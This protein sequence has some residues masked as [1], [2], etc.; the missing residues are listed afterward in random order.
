M[1]QVEEVKR[2]V[3]IVDIVGEKVALK[4]AGRN[5]KGL[6]PFHGERTPSFM[7][8]EELQIYKCFGCGKGGDVISFVEETEG[9]DF[10]EALKMLADRV[11]VKLVLIKD[12]GRSE[13]DKMLAAHDL[14][15]R[16]YK[17]LL[18]KHA[19]GKVGR[20][21]LTKRGINE[22]LMETF[23]L[24]FAPEGWENLKK[25]LVDKKGIN[26][27]MLV[28]AGLLGKSSKGIYYD[29]F[30]GRVIFP[31][32]DYRGRVVALAGRV[33]PG[34]VK[35]EESPKYINSPESLIYHKSEVLYGLHMVKEKIRKADRVVI[36]EGELDM[37]SSFAAGVGETVAIKG[38]ALT[39]AQVERLSRLTKNVVMALDADVAGDVAMKRGIE[40]AERAGM[41]IKVVR[42]VGGKDPDDVARENPKKWKLMVKKAVDIYEFYIES[43]VEKYGVETVEGKRKVSEEVLPIL[44]RI[45]NK[46]IEAHYVKKIAEILEV[47]EESVMEEMRRG[48]RKVAVGR[49]E[50]KAEEKKERVM[51]RREQ[52]ER[53][54][55]I[56]LMQNGGKVE[57]VEERL[58]EMEWE[59][60]AGE[61]VGRL[62][63]SMSKDLAEFVKKLPG[64]LRETG[65]EMYM[66]LDEMSDGR[67]LMMAVEELEKMVVREKLD[68]L[69]ERIKK[70]EKDEDEEELGK[71]RESFV[72]WSK[73][74]RE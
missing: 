46:V 36:V 30:R 68:R 48:V 3:N 1:D 25:F 13:K 38:S 40:I 10:T 8:N 37:I 9:M 32:H 41:S 56:G 6:C 72:F 33:V 50:A 24:G 20:D 15:M 21:Y 66:Q 45:S 43:A 4:K 29:R 61:I 47:G 22:K 55:L 14:A 28:R 7:V 65:E 59:S 51:S 74:L 5:Y 19:V 53:E 44:A 2:K 71:L 49:G 12:E 67:G 58:K 62:I 73:K 16:F 52:L 64:E 39:E 63:K 69:N 11:G 57:G 31:L 18:R 35:D 27:E 42:I 60:A 70:A 54:I 26:A 34:V 23:E 17:F